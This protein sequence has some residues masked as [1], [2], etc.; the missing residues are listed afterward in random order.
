MA[1]NSETIQYI[2]EEPAV[3]RGRPAASFTILIVDDDDDVHVTTKRTLNPFYTSNNAPNFL[4]AYN[5][6]EAF[7]IL[8]E[9][10][11][12]AIILLDV[13]METTSAGLTLINTIRNDLQ[14]SRTQ[15]ILRTGQPGHAREDDVV[16]DYAINGYL[17]KASLTP[18]R[19]FSAITTAHRAYT[20]LCKQ[21][22]LSAALEALLATTAQHV[23]DQSL[24]GFTLDSMAHMAV[25]LD[26][27]N[28]GLV[29]RRNQANQAVVAVTTKEFSSLS[30]LSLNAIGDDALRDR[31]ET[32]L[33]KQETIIDPQAATFFLPGSS[34]SPAVMHVPR[35]PG[36]LSDRPVEQQLVDLAINNYVRVSGKLTG[37]RDEVGQMAMGFVR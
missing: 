29:L 32:C 23:G 20:Q 9:N 26:T 10:R 6:I 30:G 35:A 8:S 21:A 36:N 1:M 31:I 14:L 19:L 37:P 2:A 27:P 4:H 25:I 3:L 15:I 12:I 34:S 17:S 5:S 22:A 18:A 7:K 24:D 33:R 13:V 16:T 11:D 28:A